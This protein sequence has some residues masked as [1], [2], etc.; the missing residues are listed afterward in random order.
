MKKFLSCLV[1]GLVSVFLLAS[2]ALAEE[3]KTEYFTL[4]LSDGW[5]MPKPVQSA[6][7]AVVAI[8]QYPDG[9][10]AVSVTVTPAP[11]P[12]K[13]LAVQTLNNMKSGGLTVSEPVA[14][15]DSYVGEFS[16][17][18]ARGVSY[19][20]SNGKLGS[21]ITI[22]GTDTKPGKD[23]LNKNFKSADAKL[24]PASF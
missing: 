22:V 4:A 1:T 10:G 20:T 21:V 12:A 8:V 23:F 7:G 14:A 16:Q 19:F 3:V 18:Q 24:F 5:T 15:G 9:K 2:V 13:D 17:Q 11:L 6:N